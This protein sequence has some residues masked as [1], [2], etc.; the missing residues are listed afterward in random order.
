VKTL[1]WRSAARL[2]HT[3]R[4]LLLLGALSVMSAAAQDAQ[5]VCGSLENHYGPYDYRTERSARLRIVER[6]HFTP[7]VEALIRGSTG[8][9]GDD[10]NYTLMTSPN[11]HRALIAM[12]RL[13]ER[14]KSQQAPNMAYSVNCFFDR[15]VRFQPDDTVVRELYAQYL[16]KIGRT[17]EAIRQLEVAEGFVKENALS[18]YNIGLIYFELKEYERALAQAHIASRQGYTRAELSEKLKSVGKWQEPSTAS[19][20]APTPAASAMP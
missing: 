10:L 9:V 1:P 19:A 4:A 12:T 18:H 17:K 14:A 11:H 7:V 15:A 13:A 16:G 8:S 20:D 2:R 6:F 5:P 3:G